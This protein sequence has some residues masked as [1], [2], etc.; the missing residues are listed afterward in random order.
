MKLYAV[1]DKDGVQLASIHESFIRQYERGDV[2][3]KSIHTYDP[4]SQVVV[5]SIAYEY[6]RQIVE[7]VYR[8]AD[9]E[10]DD[11]A[12]QFLSAGKG[13]QTKCSC[14]PYEYGSGNEVPD[15]SKCP[16]H[17]KEAT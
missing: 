4:A 16:V 11:T 2:V 17:G 1:V 8:G 12:K 15:N 7:D 6:A 13:I 10:P 9:C 5:D 3:I 14:I